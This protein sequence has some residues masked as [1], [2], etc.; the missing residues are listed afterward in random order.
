VAVDQHPDPG[1]ELLPAVGRSRWWPALAA[2]VVVAAAVQLVR[3]DRVQTLP[4]A[5][6]AAAPVSPRPAARPAPLSAVVGNRCP[7]GI[8]CGVSATVTA[9]LATEFRRDFP[10]ATISLQ[11]SAFD[12]GGPRIYWQQ[13]SATT[14]TGT[15]VVLT[16]QRLGHGSDR[17]PPELTTSPNGSTVTV[18]RVRA[19]WLVIADLLGDGR[20][21]PPVDAARRWVG[22]APLP[23]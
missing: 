4:G 18:R 19:G 16:E 7:T 11:A 1:E 6:R 22:A 23:R 10:D 8:V 12:A 14:P 2:V 5:G 3:H 9:G 20:S 13:I 17:P 15:V 21:A